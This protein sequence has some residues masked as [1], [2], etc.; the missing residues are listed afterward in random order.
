MG[1]SEPEVDGEPEVHPGSTSVAQGRARN[2][3]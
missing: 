1:E 2:P 3:K